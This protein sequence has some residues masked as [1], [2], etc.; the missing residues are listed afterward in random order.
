MKLTGLVRC[1]GTFDHGQRQCQALI[2][3]GKPLCDHCQVNRKRD[4]K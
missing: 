2:E 1:P 3:P 4:R